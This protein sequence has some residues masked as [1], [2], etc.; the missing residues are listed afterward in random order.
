MRYLSRLAALLAL[1][2][3]GWLLFDG[4]R[5]FLA[6]DYVTPS[7]GA[8]AGQLGPWAGVVSHVGLDP[9]STLVKGIHMALGSL[10]LVSAYRFLREKPK[11]GWALV[12]CAFASLWYVPFGTIIGVLELIL[13]FLY[14]RRSPGSPLFE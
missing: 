2:L 10:W 3:G 14:A 4:S 6:G 8:Y 13:L 1:A 12:A 11:A 7:S 5:A 9:R